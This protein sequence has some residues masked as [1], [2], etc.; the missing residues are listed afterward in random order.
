VQ[1]VV[2]EIV[3]KGW[4]AGK[5][6]DLVGVLVGVAA[7]AGLTGTTTWDQI[8]PI[9]IVAVLSQ[10]E[11]LSSSSRTSSGDPSRDTQSRSGSTT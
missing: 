8:T 1:H 3:R 11:A 9:Q 6:P 10:V 2:H 4:E 5:L 7:G